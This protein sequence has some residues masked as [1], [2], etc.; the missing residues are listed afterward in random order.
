MTCSKTNTPFRGAVE[1]SKQVP[2]DLKCKQ[3]E[4]PEKPLQK[5]FGMWAGSLK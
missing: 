1:R 5:M 4:R 2:L 3:Q